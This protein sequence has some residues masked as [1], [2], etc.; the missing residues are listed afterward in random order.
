MSAQQPKF[1]DED[2]GGFDDF[3]FE[4]DVIG[5]SSNKFSDAEKHLREFQQEQ[6]EGYK[7]EHPNAAKD[8]KGRGGFKVAIGGIPNKRNDDEDD[9]D[10][11]EIIEEDIQTDRDEQNNIMRGVMGGG[12]T[13]SGGQYG[14]GITVSQSLGVDPSV[15][16]LALDEFDHIEKVQNY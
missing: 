3:D 15:D 8:K 13:E 5:D 10:D 2:S 1:K 12:L 11:E 4:E 16:S 14:G 9:N 6:E 7:F